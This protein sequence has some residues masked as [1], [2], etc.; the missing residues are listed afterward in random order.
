MRRQAAVAKLQQQ[1]REIRQH[2]QAHLAAIG[3]IPTSGPIY[4]LAKGPDGRLYVIGGR[5]NFL[6]P[7]AQSAQEKLELARQLRKM[8]LAPAQPSAKD[9]SVAAQAAQQINQARRELAAEERLAA[10]NG[11]GPS[12]HTGFGITA[13]QL[14]GEARSILA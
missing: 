11:K 10:E 5:V 2:E 7:P 12:A 1:D 6:M 3:R 13:G 9:R 4:R 14:T 8:A